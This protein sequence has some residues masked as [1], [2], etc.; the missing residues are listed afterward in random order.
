MLMRA[1]QENIDKFESRFG[2][3]K[4]EGQANPQFG[5]TSAQKEE[6]VN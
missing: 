6:K 3:I 1:L 4:I 5:F 2:E